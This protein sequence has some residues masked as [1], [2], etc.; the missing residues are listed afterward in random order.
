MDRKGAVADQQIGA[1]R[2]S[3]AHVSRR[4][5]HIP[6]L[7]Q[8]DAGG[9]QGAAALSGLD[10]HYR[11]GDTRDDPV[12]GR[13][14]P[15]QGAG[16]R[17]RLAPDRSA[18]LEQLLPELLVAAR[19]PD[20][21]PGTEHRRAGDRPVQR[22]LVGG[23]VDAA[24]QPADH[25]PARPGKLPSVAL[26]QPSAV[27]G[28]G[29]GA[30]YGHRRAPEIGSALEQVRRG[31]RQIAQLIG[32]PLV[33]SEEELDPRLAE[34]LPPGLRRN[35][36]LLA[37]KGR[38]GHLPPFHRPQHRRRRL[39]LQQA[40]QTIGVHSQMGEPD[41]DIGGLRARRRAGAASLGFNPHGG[42][43]CR[44]RV[45]PPAA[46]RPAGRAPPPPFRIRPDRRW[47]WPTASP[48]RSPAR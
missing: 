8:G 31:V 34:H 28:A 5:K 40:A 44:R 32:V 41:P 7:F 9:N 2:A 43:P 19:I 38:N 22:T 16:T 46:P 45:T 12:A 21:H 35:G 1:H 23:A 6:A 39:Q 24:G 29:P 15:P 47:S 37:G 26:R 20:V 3:P 17:R 30:H 36:R 4:G 18:L 27:A 13:K 48:C 14:A 25:L 11:M 10:H 42:P 33:A